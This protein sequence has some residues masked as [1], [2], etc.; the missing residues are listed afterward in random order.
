MRQRTVLAE[1][2]AQAPMTAAMLPSR[3]PG[4]AAMLE[5]IAVLLVLLWAVGYFTA[6]TMGGLIHLLLVVAVVIVA[7]RLLRGQRI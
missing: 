2:P 5:T 1:G 3:P 6:T 4:A 7:I